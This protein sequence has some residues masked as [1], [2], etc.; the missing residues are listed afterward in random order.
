MSKSERFWDRTAKG[1]A[2]Q[3]SEEDTEAITTLAHTRKYLHANDVVLDFG[4]ATG[5]YAF[6]IAPSV[7]EVQGIDI[8]GEMIAAA[9]RNAVEVNVVNVRFMQAE[10][11]DARLKDE[12]FDVILAYNILHLVEDPPRVVEKI[13]EL[14]KP[15]GV[16]ISVTPCLGAGGSLLGALIKLLS[17][18]RIVPGVHPFKPNDVETLI[19]N[20]RFD[21][22]ETQTLSGSTSNI[23]LAGRKK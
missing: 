20:A 4:C 21:L 2:G 15:G 3:V 19:S 16:F 6:E 11:T 14:L 9:K 22:L 10:I 13:R 17:F 8:S 7:K 23:F 18:L 5:K 1:C 12:S